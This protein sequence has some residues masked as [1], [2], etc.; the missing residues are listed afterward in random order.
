MAGGDKQDLILLLLIAGLLLPGACEYVDS[1]VAEAVGGLLTLIGTPLKVTAFVGCWNEGQKIVF[2]RMGLCSGRHFLRYVQPKGESPDVQAMDNRR[3]AVLDDD[4]DNHQTMVVVDL[5]CNGSDRLLANAGQRLYLNYRWLLMDSTLNTVPVAIDHYLA[6]LKE[7]P[8]LVSS[9]LFVMLKEHDNSIRFVQVYRI[10][11]H[12]ELLTENYALWN[13]SATGADGGQMIDLRTQKVTSVR[14][15]HLDGHSLRASMV[16]TNPDTMNHLTDYKDKHIDTITKVNYILTN[17]LASYL[18]AGVNYTRVATW[19]Y[20]NTTTGMWDGMIGE[21]VHDV[22]DLG[23]SP[24][25]FTTDR[26]AV[27]EYLAMTSETRSKFIFRSPKLSYTENVF[28]LPFDNVRSVCFDPLIRGLML[29]FRLQ[30]VW[31]CVIAVI[32]ISSVLLLVTLWVEWRI[33]NDEPEAQSANDAATMDA[34]L[35]DTLLMMY[36]ASCQQG[37]AVLPRSCSARTITMLT[38]TVLMFLYASYSA[39]IV[40]LLQSPST[41]IQTLEDLLASR[42]KFGVHDTVFNRH[43]FTHATEPTRKALYEQKIRRPYGPDAFIA[44]EQGVDRIR[45]GLYAFHVEQGVGYKVISETY[46]EDEKCGLQEIQYLQVIDPYYAIQKNSSYKEMVKI[47][48]FRLNEHGIQYRE[49]AKLYT[50]K[51]TCSGGGGKFVPV[52]LVDVEPAV[53]IILWGSGLATGFFLTECFYCRCVRGKIRQM[54]R[55]RLQKQ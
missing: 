3:I 8:V 26:I 51:P 11:R 14:R 40:A 31:M 42:L 35:R 22:A 34:N 19:G 53:W 23:A 21:L 29:C 47:G 50:K 13:R 1:S 41:K 33:A 17:Y 30:N 46:Q 52:S 18:G 28:V 16:I 54:V 7:L 44:L 38:F 2:A 9:E 20:Y 27:I 32:V 45:H 24:L 49:N 39:N 4:V 25:F 12:A 6:A 15:K 36:G 37:S 48:L 10:S 43:Y 5:R 55:A